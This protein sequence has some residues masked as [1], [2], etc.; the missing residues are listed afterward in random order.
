MNTTYKIQKIKDDEYSFDTRFGLSYSLE[1]KKSN[2]FYKLSDNNIK[3]LDIFR[4]SIFDKF[5]AIKSDYIVRNTILDFLIKYFSI[6][7][8]D[9]I[10]FFINNELDDIHFTHRA[11]SRLKLFR[12]LFRNVNQSNNSDF[13]FL[14]NE[15]FVINHQEY[16]MDYI[17]IIINTSSQNYINIVKTFNK[18]CH[19]NSYQKKI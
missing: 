3:Y 16:K 6:Q 1:L 14:T 18:F 10:L 2:A 15:H 5:D 12:R 13:V 9:A 17:G 4:F 8:N 7:N 19:E 11:K